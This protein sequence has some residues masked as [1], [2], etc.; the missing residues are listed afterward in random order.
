MIK[1]YCDFRNKVV[2][3]NPFPYEIV[4]LIVSL[5]TREKFPPTEN[6][7]RVRLKKDN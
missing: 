7:D 6:V 1:N 3:A 4:G 5:P 2:I